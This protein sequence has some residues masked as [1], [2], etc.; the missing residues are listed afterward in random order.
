MKRNLSILLAMSIG[1]F[2]SCTNESSFDNIESENNIVSLSV[3]EIKVMDI[4]VNGSSI[5][6]EIA[7]QKAFSLFNGVMSKSNQLDKLECRTYWIKRFIKHG[8]TKAVSEKS[9]S[10]PL[11]LI[12]QNNGH[13]ALISGDKRIPEIL[14]FSDKQL[15]M[16]KT[17]TALD[18]FIE[19]L[20]VFINRAIDDFECKYDSILYSIQKRRG[21]ISLRSSAVELPITRLEEDVTPW[22]TVYS[23][24]PLLNVEWGQGYPYNQAL[25]KILCSGSLVFPPVGCVAVSIA[26]IIS[27]HKYPAVLD[28]NNLNWI[29]MTKTS[30][31]NSLPITYQNQIANLMKSVAL[32]VDMQF[33]C[34]G[35]SSYIANAKNFLSKIGYNS[36]NIA[37]Y[38]KGNVIA[39]I[40]NSRPFYIEGSS[41]DGRHAWVVDGVKKQDRYITQYTYEYIGSNSKPSN[42]IDPTEW[43][44]KDETITHQEEEYV[45]CNYG[46]EGLYDGY[47]LHGVFNL[48]GDSY[49]G[50]IYGP[51]F[52]SDLLLLTN[53]K[54]K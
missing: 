9:D 33:G 25:D 35:S 1:F 26:Q 50:K 52:N 42:P 15:F 24:A 47:Y 46:Y 29:E 23:Y 12:T 13:S 49:F 5:S 34:N 8:I 18:I 4:E 27:F 31:I 44:L 20:P 3:D 11:Y 36:D 51:S 17:G 6:E 38:N 53:I 41:S 30:S 7:L 19:R 37:K 48:Q 14:A 2:T 10:I 21:N 39:S 54:R 22:T 28:G 45:H 40:Q 43:V 32:G 16:E